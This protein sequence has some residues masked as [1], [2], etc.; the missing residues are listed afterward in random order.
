MSKKVAK[1]AVNRNYMRRV[2]REMYRN[3]EQQFPNLDLVIRVQSFFSHADYA[4][5]EQEFKQLAL[6]LQK[7]TPNKAVIKIE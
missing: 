1:L 5:V 3:Y 6:K 2:L 4:Q 7:I